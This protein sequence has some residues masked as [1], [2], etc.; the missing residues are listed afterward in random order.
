[1]TRIHH[2]QLP[3]RLS[4]NHPDR[5]YHEREWLLRF[6]SIHSFTQERQNWLLDAY[7]RNK[8][9]VINYDPDFSMGVMN[10]AHHSFLV[11][12]PNHIAEQRQ[13]SVFSY[14]NLWEHARKNCFYRQK[15]MDQQADPSIKN[16]DS[17]DLKNSLMTPDLYISC[18]FREWVDWVQY[19]NIDGTVSNIWVELDGQI[20]NP[21]NSS[22]GYVQF[23]RTTYCHEWERDFLISQIVFK[24]FQEAFREAGH[25]NSLS[26]VFAKVADLQNAVYQATS[27]EKLHE[28]FFGIFSTLYRADSSINML[29]ARNAIEKTLGSQDILPEAVPTESYPKFYYHFR[30]IYNDWVHQPESYYYIEA[31][32]KAPADIKFSRKMAKTQKQV[33]SWSNRLKEFIVSL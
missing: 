28:Q 27:Y 22:D 3:E 17:Q 25:Y 21:K 1:M 8:V 29:A 5:A 11:I 33:N 18:M 13:C 32:D 14:K 4:S 24:Q 12:N 19:H 23:Y 16:G 6:I 26:E 15:D 30:E 9:I 20:G 7:R 2:S 31:M 10:T